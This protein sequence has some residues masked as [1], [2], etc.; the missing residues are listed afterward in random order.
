MLNIMNTTL[1]INNNSFNKSIEKIEE[2]DFLSIFDTTEIDIKEEDLLSVIEIMPNINVEAY[3]I[4]K[5][6]NEVVDNNL[7]NSNT[8]EI[9][10]LNDLD[11]MN[12]IIKLENK[13]LNNENVDLKIKVDDKLLNVEKTSDYLNRSIKKVEIEDEILKNI[14]SGKVNI[15]DKLPSIKLETLNL[16][17]DY[18]I[19]SL[20]NRDI[21]VLKEIIN[22]ENIFVNQSINKNTL[23]INSNEFEG[24]T[25]PIEIRQNHLSKDI[26]KTISYLKNND[27]QNL[28]LNITPKNLGELTINLTKSS[29]D[30]KILITI[31]EPES[32]N[33]INKN[34]KEITQHLETA[35]IN[36]NQIVV[37]VKTDNKGLFGDSLS[38][39]FKDRNNQNQGS[40]QNKNKKETL[41]K[42]NTALSK[43]ENISILA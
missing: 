8:V 21:N 11:I 18:K 31:S 10:D 3:N 28:K 5:F 14:N 19:N 42:E 35:N 25:K 36:V 6:Q 33:L 15:E 20:E 34:L 16:K 12:K 39:Q 22:D 2:L 26:V 13:N 32:F 40:K 7:R 30:T 1:G 4:E 29:E 23:D 41:E 17:N 38:Q 27:I 37:E 43:D 24:E 9:S